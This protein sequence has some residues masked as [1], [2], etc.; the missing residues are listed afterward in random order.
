[1]IEFDG[2]GGMVPGYLAT[3]EG[4]GPF[5]GVVVLQEYWG[6]NEQ[7]KG[8]ADRLARNGFAALV[9]DLY[10]GEIARE[11]DEARKLAMGLDVPRAMQDIQ[12]AVNYLIARPD[13]QPKEAGV[14]GFCMGGKLAARM[15]YKGDRIAAAVVFYGDPPLEEADTGVPAPYLGLYGGEDKS[16]PIPRVEEFR[17]KLEERGHDSEIVVY[18]DAP[19]AF[20]NEERP[21]YRPEAAED[22]WRRTLDW[23]RRY[24]HYP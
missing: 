5:P 16:I 12:G 7:I 3:P 2:S 14:L 20:A 19:H 10:R 22:A 24:I 18:P 13:V 21:A 4:D 8:V 23:L 15:A 1:M 9:P 11:P 17:A 6:L